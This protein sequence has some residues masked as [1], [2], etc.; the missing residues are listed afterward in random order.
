MARRLMIQGTGSHVGKS[1]IVAA[2]CRIFANEGYEVAP[3]KS[4]NMSLNSFITA[5]GHEIARSQVF[6]ALAARKEPVVEMNPIL[7]KPTS[8]KGSQVILKGTPVGNM[9]TLQYYAFKERA[10][11]AIRECFAKLD[12]D[13]DIVVIEGAGSPA[14]INLRSNDIVNMFI[15]KIFNAPVIIV[16]DIE[17][18]GVFASLI[19]TLELL[20]EDEKRLVKGFIINKFRGDLSILQPGLDFL[21]ERTNR[22]VI[23][24]I[25]YFNHIRIQEED[26]LSV[27]NFS[28]ENVRWDGRW[29]NVRIAVVRLPHISNFTDFDALSAERDVSLIY[30]TDADVLRCADVIILPGSKNTIADLMWLEERGI[31]HEIKKAAFSGN[32]VVFGICGGFQMMTE[33]IIDEGGVESSECEYEGLGLFRA[34]TV[35]LSDKTTHQV[36]ARSNLPF[37]NGSVMGYEI[38][39][40]VTHLK[41]SE[42][43]AFTIIKR[44]NKD[45]R[46]RDGAERGNVIG[47]YIHG[48]FDNDDF[49]TAFIE[50]AENRISDMRRRRKSIRRKSRRKRRRSVGIDWDRE[51]D[52]LAEFVRKNLNMEKIYEIIS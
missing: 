18:G 14:E 49:R 37:F 20:H 44:S 32:A 3:F 35:F 25:P 24:V 4:Q 22:H 41:E 50:F 5:D 19:G 12:A 38:H 34:D 45:V 21:E 48:I 40:G 15:A 23:G 52:K 13:N 51:I 16:G 30:T 7:L 33:R 31:A 11:A 43:H 47:T 42:K 17:R 8:E 27:E 2:L 29:G 9:T 1:V 28:V 10:V 36:L 6:Q 26:S 39:M 46:V